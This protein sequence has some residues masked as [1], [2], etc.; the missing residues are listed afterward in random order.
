MGKGILDGVRIV[1]FGWAVVGPLTCSWAGNYGAEVIKI[2]TSGR[3]DHLRS[4]NPFKGNR[5]GINNSAYFNRENASKYS[6]TIDLKKPG[7]LEIAKGLIAKSDVVVDSYTSGVMEKLGLSYPELRDIKPDLIMLRSCMFGQTGALRSM[8]GYGVTLTAMCGLTYLCG[9]PDRAPSGPYGAYTDY[10][11]PRMNLL[12]IAAALDYRRRTGKGL[13]IDASQ[14]ES[15]IQFMAPWILDCEVNIRVAERAGNSSPCAAPHGVYRCKG[16]ERWCAIGVF[17]EQEWRGFCDAMDN[18]TWTED[19]RFSTLE[20]RKKNEEELNRLVQEWTIERNPRE[21]MELMQKHGVP[22]GMLNNGKDLDN[23]PQLDH[24]R[25][26]VSRRHPVMGTVK[27]A[28]HS[29]DFPRF[30]QKVFRSPCIGEH[31]EYVCKKVLGMSGKEYN[32][33]V[34]A[35]DLQ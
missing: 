11:V 8:P 16:K 31:T 25:Y 17:S 10:L 29:I 35:G 20:E 30:S 6:A 23:D 19:A 5:P 15:A 32:R 7:G 14:L 34:E 33:H 12:A 22:A 2:E 21:V 27:Y 13:C 26:Y 4:M 3:P 24:S 1:E 28:G 18:Q 9:W